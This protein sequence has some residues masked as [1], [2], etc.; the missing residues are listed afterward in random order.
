MEVSSD[1]LQGLYL[2]LIDHLINAMD[3][4]IKYENYSD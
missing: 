4:K 1:E 3:D 2:T